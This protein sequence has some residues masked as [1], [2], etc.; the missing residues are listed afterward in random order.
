VEPLGVVTRRS[1]E[2]LALE[3]PE[4]AAALRFLHDHAAEPIGVDDLVAHLMISRRSLEI[5]FRRE[6]G[7]TIHEELQ[8]VRLERAMR[9]LRETD[10]PISRVASGAGFRS[11]SYLAQVFRQ[12]VGATP[13]RYRGQLRTPTS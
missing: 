2:I 12:V 11:P 13:A 8:R 6:T 4:V 5:R 7:R 3:D 9:L 10:L 1:T